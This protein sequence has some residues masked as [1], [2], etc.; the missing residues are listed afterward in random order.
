MFYETIGNLKS[1]LRTGWV[2]RGI[3]HSETVA[4]H[5]YRAQFIAYDLAK[6]SGIDPVSCAHMMLIHDLPEA[7]AKVGDLTHSCGVTQDE[8]AA[9]EMRAAQDFARIS[10]NP[11]FLEIFIEFEEKKTLRAQICND[12]DQL[13][14]LMQALEYARLYPEKRGVLEDFWPYAREKLLTIAGKELFTELYRQKSLLDW[15][16]VVANRKSLVPF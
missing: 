3:P 12:A 2:K 11:E 6:K 4:A 7:D 1:L 10:G 9:L 16:W 15:P 8:K 5:M 14:C 13:E